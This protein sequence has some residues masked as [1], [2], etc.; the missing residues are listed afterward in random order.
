MPRTAGEVCLYMRHHLRVVGP[1]RVVIVVGPHRGVVAI[2]GFAVGGGLVLMAVC[3]LRV[4]AENAEMIIPEIDLGIPLAWGGIPK[5]V[6]EIGPALTKELV[7]TCRRFTPAEAKAAGFVNRVVPEARLAAEADA[8]AAELAAK[9]SAP[10][11]ITK[12]HVNSVARTMG[13]GSTAFADGD[14]LLGSAGDEESR[15]AARVYMEKAFG[16]GKTR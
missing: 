7:M 13:T 6:R 8:L 3:D 9:P 16:K 14:T 5:L 2:H 12:E 11:T 15:E 4:V 10:I 1:V